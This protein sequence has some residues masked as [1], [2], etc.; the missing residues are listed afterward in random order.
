LTENKPT[1]GGRKRPQA[2]DFLLSKSRARFNALLDER[3]IKV[4][5]FNADA[6]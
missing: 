1:A 4:S 6:E 2:V 3:A 5:S